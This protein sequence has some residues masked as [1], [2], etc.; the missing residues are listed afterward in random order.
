MS[1]NGK[2]RESKS[3]WAKGLLWLMIGLL[4]FVTLFPFFWVIRTSFT[5]QV[6][7]F[8]R[9]D[10]CYPIGSDRNSLRPCFRID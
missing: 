3:R 10:L 8:Y 9:T 7:D 1:E 6:S 2:I 5:P 4:L